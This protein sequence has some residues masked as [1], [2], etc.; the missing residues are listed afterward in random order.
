MNCS[1]INK[2]PITHEQFLKF[3]RISSNYINCIP[4]FLNLD[5]NYRYIMTS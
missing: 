2:K 1:P 5:T 4:Y 3:S